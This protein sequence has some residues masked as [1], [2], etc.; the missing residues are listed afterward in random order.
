MTSHTYPQGTTLKPK[1]PV[2]FKAN[3]KGRAITFDTDARLWV[4]NP[5][6]NQRASGWV[7]VG[8]A[9]CHK[10]N[11]GYAFTPEQCSMLFDIV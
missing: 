8:R 7:M 10:I 1:A 2:Q 11:Q 4:T 5:Q 3:G 6:H 9:T